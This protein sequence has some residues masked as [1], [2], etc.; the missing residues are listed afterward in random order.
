MNSSTTNQ[1]PLFCNHLPMPQC[2]NIH[3]RC[4]KTP[5]CW[6]MCNADDRRQR[7]PQQQCSIRCTHQRAISTV[8]SRTVSD[9]CKV[10]YK[11]RSL[12]AIF[13]LFWVRL[14]FK[15]SFYLRTAYMQ[16][17]EFVKS[18]KAVWH[19]YNESETWHSDHSK[20]T[21]N[22]NKNLACKKAVGICP[23]STTLGLR[24]LYECGLCATWVRR[25]C[26]F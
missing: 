5:M 12:C 24:L 1:L 2:S 25:K 20:I 6:A 19:L 23:T 7:H 26:G 11:S 4:W 3:L 18:V 13:R 14:L 17:A 21:S 22:V 9:Y 16:N 10:V 8:D 15:R